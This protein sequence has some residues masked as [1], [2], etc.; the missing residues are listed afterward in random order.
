MGLFSDIS[1]VA[2]NH[3]TYDVGLLQA[4]GYRILKHMTAQVLRPEGL[5]TTE[6]AMIGIISHYPQGVL[7][8]KIAETLSVHP[9]L[10]SRL[11]IKTEA[12]GWITIE[13]GEDKRQK[14]VHLSKKSLKN[15]SRI[16]KNVRE[17]LI[18]LLKGVEPKDLAGYL[19][20]L[21][22]ISKNGKDFPSASLKDYIPI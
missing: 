14:V 4:R 3:T 13:Q 8:Q 15:I 7:A 1:L 9:P 19:R 21:D 22:R 12:S 10:V 2:K 18:P 17:S 20:T 16:E 5:T 11:L 6:W